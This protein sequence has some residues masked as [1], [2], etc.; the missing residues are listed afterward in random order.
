MTLNARNAEWVIQQS[1][2]SSLAEVRDLGSQ[3]AK[4]LKS[5]TPSLIKYTEPTALWKESNEEIF[6][7]FNSTGSSTA[8]DAEVSLIN[9][10]T[11]AE[12]IIS[13]ALGLRKGG[14]SIE[15]L[16][17]SVDRM[18]EDERMKLLSRAHMYLTQHSPVRREL[19]LASFTF[20]I[21]LSASAFAQ[22]KRHRI[23]TIISQPYD[24]NL[25][26]T[27]PPAVL[28]SGLESEFRSFTEYAERGYHELHKLLPSN[29]SSVAQYSLTNAHRR[30]VIFHANAREMIH[31]SRLR[32]D[33]HAQWDIRQLSGKMAALAKKSCPS[34]M[35]LAAGKDEFE[36]VRAELESRK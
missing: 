11:Q 27:I 10:P 17:E 33:S 4:I 7:A 23:A 5:L 22:L 32:E 19:E 36:T 31:L 14:L 18:G 2:H 13:A 1:T 12:R 35:F 24:P 9:E 30:R 20:G 6:A 25:G 16:L 29:L 15:S 8:T 3:M 28:E 26:V 21:T 34:L